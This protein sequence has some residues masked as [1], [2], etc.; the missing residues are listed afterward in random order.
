M[1]HRDEPRLGGR[2]RDPRPHASEGFARIMPEPLRP[3]RRDTRTSSRLGSVRPELDLDVD[4]LV[5]PA[6][7]A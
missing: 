6:G 3:F 4:R 1:E 5:P 7:R 2:R